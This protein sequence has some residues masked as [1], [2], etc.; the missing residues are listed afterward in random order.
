MTAPILQNLLGRRARKPSGAA[1]A[2]RAMNRFYSVAVVATVGAPLAT[3]LW[4]F[5]AS[6]T[7]AAPNG[8]AQRQTTPAEAIYAEAPAPDAREPITAGAF[9]SLDSPPGGL[10]LQPDRKIL[11]AASLFGFYIDPQSGK[12]GQ[13]QRGA[14]RLNPNGSLD[15]SFCCRVEFP[16]SDANRA[17]LGLQPDGRIVISGLFDS[18]D[19]KPRPG[20]ARLLDDGRVDESFVPWHGSPHSPARTYLPGGVYPAAALS[21][22]SV[23]VMSDAVEG[24]R[25][26]YPWTAYRLDVSGAF[27]MPG[28]KTLAGGVFSRPS[29]LLLTLGPVGFWARKTIDWTR[30]TP[31][32]RR[33]PFT[34]G[35]PASDLPGG[36]PVTDAPFERWTESPSAADAAVVLGGLFEETPLELCRYAV[37][38]P[39]GGTLLALRDAMAGG[40]TAP[41]R[42]MR[43]DKNWQPDF[44]FT[45]HFEADPRCPLT[46][47]RQPDGNHF[48]AG[49]A[50]RMNG[51]EVSGLVRLNADGQI[52]AGFQCRTDNSWQGRVVDFAVQ[53]DGRII[54]CGCF[55]RVNGIECQHLAR[56][57]PDGSLD[58]TFKNPFISLQQLNAVRFPVHSL[59]ATTDPTPAAPATAPEVATG[60][61][62]TILIASFN[63]Q[64]NGAVIHFTGSPGKTY[65]LQA[66]DS[67]ESA[68]W[69]NVSATTA[70]ANGTGVFHDADMNPHPSRFYRV[71]T[72]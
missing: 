5:D 54:I 13:F 56:L 59:A 43:F 30:P 33:P 48:L 25:A 12:L 35:N 50:G 42:I 37:R 55:T 51:E 14:I 52:D 7:S 66:K 11:V 60:P 32:N 70:D 72:P 67:L 65:I 62:E 22:G 68:D 20:Y 63:R 27:I 69:T 15:R 36:S 58:A 57:N 17:H 3:A 40:A 29:G 21:D 9:M 24:P 64:D 46:L 6:A 28:E 71:A 1:F 23:A 26:P 53:S 47:K 19:A 49:L 39:D 8:A 18:V 31:A 2:A 61:A 41:G 10:L 34:A 4:C 16:G 45:N 44:S 38:L